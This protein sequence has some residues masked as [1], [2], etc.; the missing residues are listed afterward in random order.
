MQ[1]RAINTRSPFFIQKATAQLSVNCEIR[2]WT[3]GVVTN[4]P[5]AYT[6]LL[7]K[8]ATSGAAT[9]EVAELCR[10]YLSHNSSLSSGT[11][12]VEIKTIDGV[13]ADETFTYLATEGYTTYVD[14]LQSN[15]QTVTLPIVGLPN[16]IANETRVMIP[17]GSTGVIPY[18][19]NVP[20]GSVDYT[21][22]TYSLA[23]ASQGSSVISEYTN[24]EDM[25]RHV[26]VNSTMKWVELDFGGSVQT[27]HVDILDCNKFE[28]IELMYV[29]RLGMKQYFP[30]VLKS[31]EQIKLKSDT[32][33]RSTIN[34]NSLNSGNGLHASRKRITGSK[35]SFTLNTDWMSEYY[36]KQFEELLLSE[37]VWLF[38]AGQNAI[39]VNVTTSNM[40]KKNHLNDK[41][42]NYS[43]DIET[44]S[45]YINNVR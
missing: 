1:Y 18:L 30:F 11:A 37:Y 39:P 7:V 38:K 28:A 5:T 45:E 43:L 3:G 4:R 2:L 6:Y 15:T 12:W 20:T 9:F 21:L 22:D 25:I 23:G 17:S 29:N 27:I 13:A 33:N 8:E 41:L 26:V 10:D 24:S 19:A 34:Y 31:T 44:A 14:G 42:I 32:F 40:L 35:Q 16:E 36:V